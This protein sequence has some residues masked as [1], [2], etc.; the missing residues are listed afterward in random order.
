[1][2][3]GLEIFSA[4]SPHRGPLSWGEGETISALV[5]IPAAGLE[6]MIL[7]NH[8]TRWLFLLP[9]GEGQDEGKAGG[10]F[11]KVAKEYIA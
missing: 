11:D 10:H 4:S 3:A 9:R 6:A 1:M 8:E 5:T 2:N 7:A